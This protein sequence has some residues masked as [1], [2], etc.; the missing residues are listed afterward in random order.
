MRVRAFPVAATLLAGAVAGGLALTPATA[1]AST[2]H[3]HHSSKVGIGKNSC[4]AANGSSVHCVVIS[5]SSHYGHGGYY[6]KDGYYYYHGHLIGRGLGKVVEGVGDV[7][8]GV[9]YAL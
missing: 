8:Q 7:L 2:S 9:L 6:Y 5:H 1:F 3:S 4:N